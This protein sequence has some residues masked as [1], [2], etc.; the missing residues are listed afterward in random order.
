MTTRAEAVLDAALELPQDELESVVERLLARLEPEGE[1]AD[2]DAAWAA[3]AERRL[4]ELARGDVKP[5]PWA[6]VK[7]RARARHH[8][9]G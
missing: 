7:A 2:V 6:E 3:E 4:A 8:G 1:E 5:I 9:R